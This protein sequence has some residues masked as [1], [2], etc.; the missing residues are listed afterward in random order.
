MAATTV[1]G[2]VLP[3]GGPPST[4]R[5]RWPRRLL[6]GL[7]VL[8]AVCVVAAGTVY[9]YANYRFGQIKRVPVAGLVQPGAVY[10]TG[11]VADAPGTP[12]NILVIGSDSRANMSAADVRAFGSSQQTPDRNSDTIMIVHLDPAAKSA[13]L[14]SIP[15]DLYVPISGTLGKAKINSTYAN[16]PTLLVRTIQ[17]NFGIL[18]NH[19][20]ETD[21]TSFRQVVNSIA[22]V[23]FWY[24]E[25]VRDKET[26]LNITKP[27][28]YG[29]DGNMALALVR[30]RY[31]YYEENGIWISE[32]QSD[33]ARIRRQQLFVKK[34]ISKAQDAGLTNLTTLN[35]VIGGVVSN[36]TIDTGFSR[37]EML[38]LTR[39]YSQFN[40]ARL[41]TFTLPAVDTTLP[42]K[43]EVLL[44]VPEDTQVV[45]AF[46]GSP[47]APSPGAPASPAASTAPTDPVPQLSPSTVSVGVQNGSGQ[48]GQATE[49]T[50]ALRAA[51]FNASISGTGRADNFAHATTLVRYAPADA[52][53]AQ[54]LATA[55]TGGA[56]VQVD[57]T[58]AAGSVL[59]ITGA[60]YGGLHAPGATAAPASTTTTTPP[61]PPNSSQQPAFPGVHGS[62]P[63]PP[64]CS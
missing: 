34:V 14:L 58:M 3:A 57:P 19:V 4:H 30:S 62:D 45:A 39:L 35:G 51:G 49:A 56:Q 53:K 44:P 21:F 6:I 48:T 8:V 54:F 23:K 55:V 28:C 31:L 12:L 10:A 11:Q 15:R 32:A 41:T 7:N 59:L 9:G 36:L 42:N 1:S 46:L 37:S 27:G 50:N 29:L 33:L 26:G 24:P 52:G 25:P 17:D 18:I 47:G 61:V 20:V 38:R 16:G 5:R 13:S 43:A 64:G 2:S 60:S 22:P 63:A 40:P